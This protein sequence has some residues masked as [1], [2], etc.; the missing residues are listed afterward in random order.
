[1]TSRVR[2]LPALLAALTAIVGDRLTAARKS[3]KSVRVDP[4]GGAPH[5]LPG[6]TVSVSG[7]GNVHDVALGVDIGTI[8]TGKGD[9]IT[10]DGDMVATDGHFEA[11]TGGRSGFLSHYLVS[12][13]NT[14]TGAADANPPQSTPIPNQLRAINIIKA[15]ACI[16]MAVAG[17]VDS[18]RG[19]G[20]ASVVP[21]TYG[22]KG[23]FSV[24]FVTA[25]DNIDYV[26]QPGPAITDGAALY[27][28]REVLAARTATTCFVYAQA[29]GMGV[30]D[31]NAAVVDGVQFS[32][33]GQQT[34]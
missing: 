19:C 33:S 22:G 15:S 9:V 26:F 11:T 16:R 20:V 6:G 32:V 30:L 14:G 31:P 17:V 23:G 4:T 8:Q 29:I 25:F 2:D 27:F 5:T 7:T 1:M 18:F 12:F 3:L 34:T 28:P 21:G 24:T 10:L 13:T